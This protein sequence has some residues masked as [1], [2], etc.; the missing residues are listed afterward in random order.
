MIQGRVDTGSRSHC[1]GQPLGLD[2]EN[3]GAA[4]DYTYSAELQFTEPL[5]FP[6]LC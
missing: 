4:P 2:P 3:V 5:D 6:A 1:H